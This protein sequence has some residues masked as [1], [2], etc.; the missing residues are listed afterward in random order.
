MTYQVRFAAALRAKMAE[1]HLSQ[2]QVS[3]LTSVDSSIVSR[4]I[5]GRRKN[6][7]YETIATIANKLSMWLGKTPDELARTVTYL[8]SVLKRKNKIIYFL[9]VIA[10]IELIIILL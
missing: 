1:E 8:E 9:E 4:V 7:S 5:T 2:A 3:R 6:I 10:L